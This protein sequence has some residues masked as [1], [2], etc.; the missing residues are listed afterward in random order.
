MQAMP[1]SI[2]AKSSIRR[3]LT[4]IM[5]IQSVS[6]IS[7][8]R[9][10]Q[11]RWWK[12]NG[13]KSKSTMGNGM[14]GYWY[15]VNDRTVVWLSAVMRLR[16]WT[17]IFV[18]LSTFA[19]NL[20]RTVTK[21]ARSNPVII[22]GGGRVGGLNP[23]WKNCGPHWKRI[24]KAGRSTFDPLWLKRGCQSALGKARHI[25]T[26]KSCDHRFVHLSTNSSLAIQLVVMRHSSIYTTVLFYLLFVFETWQSAHSFLLNFYVYEYF[27][28][29][30]CMNDICQNCFV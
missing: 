29:S 19:S 9:W 8:R 28:Y 17:F 26:A 20:C 18:V 15:W 14:N 13:W 24:K 11:R 12:R 23:P 21:F 2:V 16:Q 25:A 22:N 30:W 5:M 4:M 3:Q 6:E 27:S 10:K 7:C 1:L